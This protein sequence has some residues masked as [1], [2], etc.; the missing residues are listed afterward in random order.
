MTYRNLVGASEQPP[1]NPRGFLRGLHHGFLHAVFT[2]P[3]QTDFVAI[4]IIQIGMAPA[5][6]H[7]AWQFGHV[8]A[9]FLEIAAEVIERSHFEI[10]TYTF[11]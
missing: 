3:I 1:L 5:P 2:G 11:A 7:H 8:E 4:G 10:Q 9:L 6:G